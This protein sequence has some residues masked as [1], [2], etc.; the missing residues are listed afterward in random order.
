VRIRPDLTGF[1]QEADRQTRA[2]SADAGLQGR[3]AGEQYGKGM[4]AGAK[5]WSP[6]ELRAQ[7]GGTEAI[8][9]KFAE[10]DANAERLKRDFPE[11]TAKLDISAAS[12]KMAI[13]RAEARKTSAGMRTLSSRVSGIGTALGKATPAW[14]G[15]AA[16]GL[17]F[18]PAIL[19]A[20]AAATAGVIGLGAAMAGAGAALGVFGL[21]AKGNLAELQKQLLKVQAANRAAAIAEQTAAG[22]RTAAQK[23]AIANAHEL[24]AAFQKEFGAEAKAI[25]KLKSSWLKFTTQPAVTNAIAQGAKLLTNVLPHLTP[26]LRLGALAVNVFTSSLS[27]FATG[28]GLDRMVA[29][30]V[31]A[32]R[33]AIIGFVAILHNLAVAFGALAGPA[34]SF[35]GGVVTGL[36][37]LSAAFATWATNKGPAAFTGLMNV[38]R[39]LGPSVVT[40]IK[41]LAAAVPNLAKGLFPLAPLSLALS[42]ALAGIIAH[43][44][45]H[46]I[47]VLAAA[48]VSLWGAVKLIIAVTKVWEAVQLVMNTILAANPIGIVVVAL[49]ALTAGVILAYQHSATFRKIVQATFGWI[50]DHWPL[51]VSI[52][53]G[54][55]GIAAVL[56]IRHF[57]AIRA[58]VLAVWGWIRGHWPLLLAILTG[59]VGLAVI[60]ILRHWRQIKGGALAVWNWISSAWDRIR[61]WLIA[62]FRAAERVIGG[63]FRTISKWISAITG[64]F[65][66]GAGGPLPGG[67]GGGV[68]PA[69]GSGPAAAQAYARAI[70]G[71]YGMSAGTQFPALQ[72]LWNNE[73]GWNY[74][75]RNASSGAYGIPQA[76]PASKM[77]SAGADWATNYKTQVRWGLGYIRSAYRLPTTA[78]AMWQARSPHWYGRGGLITEPVAGIGLR[79]GRGYGFG[80][81]GTERVTPG[82]GPADDGLIP[83]L[84][85]DLITAV[86]ASAGMTGDAVGTA[87]SRSARRAGYRALYGGA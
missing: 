66:G 70:M 62:P 21:A 24:T 45:P 23:Q 78:L 75:A 77:A 3:R 37:N 71:T 12:A 49:A 40:L 48:F 84:L 5:R 74:R 28:G 61:G 85:E 9:A 58:V 30:L 55:I 16:A 32:G 82:P 18:G 4:T 46:V 39:R 64:F 10:I 86:Y 35:A 69:R 51:L 56:I 20:L 65:S 41:S 81:H 14:T 87:L 25:E 29:F 50:K 42:T 38:V 13:L 11:F 31:R 19:P 54:P 63:I 15:F 34:S 22:K 7:L 72:Q 17:A 1:R 68:P 67:H 73:S 59:P 76:L 52:I 83:A 43:A 33:P 47:T 6:L 27:G 26:L 57:S 36:V 79:S 80:E 60:V 8:K 44:N 53:A 2:A